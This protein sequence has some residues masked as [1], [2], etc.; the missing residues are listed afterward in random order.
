MTIETGLSQD[1]A[2]R[3]CDK[4]FGIGDAE[5]EFSRAKRRLPICGNT[6]IVPHRVHTSQVFVTGLLSMCR[7]VNADGDGQREVRH[8]GGEGQAPEN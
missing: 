2:L 1:P 4:Q 7:I 6:T 8:P 5:G 3:D